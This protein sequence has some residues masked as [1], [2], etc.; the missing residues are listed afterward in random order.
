VGVQHFKADGGN[1]GCLVLM[2]PALS[3]CRCT[4]F[5]TAVR[6]A[7]ARSQQDDPQGVPAPHAGL[8]VCGQNVYGMARPFNC[9]C[10]HHVCAYALARAFATHRSPFA[11]ILPEIM[12]FYASAAHWS[13]LWSTPHLVALLIRPG[14][15]T[16]PLGHHRLN[17]IEREQQRQL[18]AEFVGTGRSCNLTDEE[19]DE[20]IRGGYNSIDALDDLTREGLA[21]LDLRPAIIDGLIRSQ[22]RRNSSV[23]CALASHQPLSSDLHV[24]RCAGTLLG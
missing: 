18:L 13:I 2:R 6:A 23:L 15:L 22:Q 7:S 17:M 14:R 3:D 9:C 11:T 12:C 24:L 4:L 21:S 5:E 20:V 10:M 1:C 16:P 8:R 19:L